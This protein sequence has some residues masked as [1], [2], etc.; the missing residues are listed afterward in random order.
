MI[1]M[2]LDWRYHPNWYNPFYDIRGNNSCMN[3]YI[4]KD[5]TIR[6]IWQLS[7]KKET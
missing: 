4:F 2:A 5:N 6:L 7:D 1:Y 3:D